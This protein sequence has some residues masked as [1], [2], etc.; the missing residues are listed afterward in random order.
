MDQIKTFSYVP[1][2]IHERAG[3]TAPSWKN[4]TWKGGKFGSNDE[5]HHQK[6]HSGKPFG[7]KVFFA[8]R[9]KVIDSNGVD[10]INGPSR[11]E[12]KRKE[13]D[14]EIEEMDESYSETEM[15]D[16]NEFKCYRT[17]LESNGVRL[18]KTVCPGMDLDSESYDDDLMKPESLANVHGNYFE[19]KVNGIGTKAIADTGA[20]III[21]GE[22]LAGDLE[23]PVEELDYDIRVRSF[24][25]SISKHRKVTTFTLQLGPVEKVV[26]GLIVP[27]A[28]KNLLLNM[29]S[30][31]RLGV[32]WDFRL[33]TIQVR[34][35]EN[36]LVPVKFVE[37]N[38]NQ[39]VRKLFPKL[40][41]SGITQDPSITVP[42]ELQ[43]KSRVVVRKA[44]DLYGRRLLWAKKKI[45][46]L[47]DLGVIE[48]S[49]SK[50]ASPCVIVTKG[51]GD[52]R[53][54]Q[55]Y[56]EINKVTDIDP[57]PFPS[58]DQIIDGFGGIKYFSKIDLKDGFWQIGLT[59]ETMHFT[60]FV[61]PFGHYQLQRLP[62]GWKNSPAKFQRIM[63]DILEDLLNTEE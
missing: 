22:Q 40:C 63:S 61:L 3:Q 59:P 51:N 7:K 44:Y 50:Y 60:A 28:G 2:P 17:K 58:I 30:L 31:C 42:F 39:E 47:L 46:E 34:D 53:L 9:V 16:G 25:N 24:K 27:E 11:R 54:T 19:V 49:T 38:W 48:K 52:Y 1:K 62:Q 37:S 14:E 33:G 4:G 18:P 36:N 55:D 8:K 26:K 15:D 32:I 10:P 6:S 23:L 41:E 12:R 21:I 20:D 29:Y 5:N 43:K 57:F 45:K 35:K 56:R 13:E